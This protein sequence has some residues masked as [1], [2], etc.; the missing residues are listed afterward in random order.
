MGAIDERLRAREIELPA[1]LAVPD[2]GFNYVLVSF[3]GS[4]AYIAGHGPQ[5]G[6]KPPLMTGRI[7]A[8]LSA[9]EGR[10]VKIS[11]LA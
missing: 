5:D 2:Q 8:D 3:A 4:I 10:P 6:G 9:E 1:P 7:G 11:E